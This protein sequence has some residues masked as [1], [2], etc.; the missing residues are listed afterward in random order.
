MGNIGD[1][2]STLLPAVGAS[3]PGYAVDYTSIMTEVMARLASKVPLSSLL[4]NSDLDINGQGILNAVY[5]SLVDVGSPAATPLNRVATYAGDLYWVGP[6]GAVQV[7]DGSGINAAGIG[8]ITGD[9]GGINPAQFRFVDAT[10]RFD[11]YDDFSTGAWASVRARSFDLSPGA[12]GTPYASLVWAG[13]PSNVTYTFP[14]APSAGMLQM[15]AGGAI[16]QSSTLPINQDIVLSG[17]GE[18]CHGDTEVVCRPP[19]SVQTSFGMVG[20]IA[21]TSVAASVSAYIGTPTLKV[22]DRIKRINLYM[23]SPV[24]GTVTFTFQAVAP[25]TSGVTAPPQSYGFTPGVNRGVITLTTPYLIPFNELYQVKIVT[26][27]A[28]T[29]NSLIAIGF[30]YDHPV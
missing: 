6:S 3:G 18:Y 21:Y 24:T 4:T 9:Y 8:G 27:A 20:D 7:T 30:V 28:S 25:Q 16:T 26:A 29:V 12:T 14:S 2:F 15:G 5:L 22:G 10:K 19:W 1:P 17:T 23:T 11:A 13:G